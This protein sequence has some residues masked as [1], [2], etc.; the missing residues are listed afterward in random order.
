M[1]TFYLTTI[2]H[3][4]R[5]QFAEVKVVKGSDAYNEAL[6]QEPPQFW[7]I[8]T[9]KLVGK[10]CSGPRLSFAHWTLIQSPG[11]LLLGCFCQTV[12]GFDGSL[13]GGL[14]ANKAFLNF[15]DGT[16]DG[17]WAAINSAM[18]QIGGVV[19]LPCVGPCVDRWGRKVG[20]NIGAWLIII[21]TIVNGTTL[22]TG[23]DGQLKAGRFILGFGVSIVSAAGPIY[24]VE[25][26]HPAWRGII[27]AYCN[28]FW[29]IG[30]I[31]SSGAVRG[32][33][34]IAGNT[35]WQIPVWLQLAFPGLIV[36]FSWG[37]PES[38]RWLFVNNRREQAVETLCKWHGYG[39]RDSSWVKL[40]IAEYEEFLDTNGAVCWTSNTKCIPFLTSSRTNAGGTTAP[41]S[42]PERAAIA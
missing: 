29:F 28:T 21:G 19:A 32:G 34:N 18:Y 27:T 25:T 38:P 10:Y 6:A 9:W 15:F 3:S 35:S 5:P 36:L 22:Y 41:C 30:S 2:I 1:S 17:P 14:T 8:T 42:R 37:I 20:M 11:C 33:L 13:F 7:C 16:N 31:L 40:Q 39:N 12:N 26:A 23:S 24:V 4:P